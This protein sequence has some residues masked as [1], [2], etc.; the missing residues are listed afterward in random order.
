MLYFKV[1]RLRNF[2]ILLQA[3]QAV[4]PHFYHLATLFPDT[5]FVDVPV[6]EKNA[7]LHQGL[8]IP[9]LPFAHIYHPTGLVEEQKLTRNQVA[10]FKVKLQSY[11]TGS[12]PIPDND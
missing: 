9:T 1:V 6:S 5:I 7:A 11:V 2:Y 4:A 10:P 3:C 8:G 12:C